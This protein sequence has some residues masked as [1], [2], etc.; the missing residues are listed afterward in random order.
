MRRTRS[1]F[2][3]SIRPTSVAAQT[4]ADAAFS[5]SLLRFLMRKGL[6]TLTEAEELFEFAL[7]L[8]QGG[9]LAASIVDHPA[10]RPV[11]ERAA[12]VLQ[13]YLHN[14]RDVPDAP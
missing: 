6:I 1:H 11:G 5:I 12:L 4:V 2:T 14:L 9:G 10:P 13:A 8:V 3:K 7:G